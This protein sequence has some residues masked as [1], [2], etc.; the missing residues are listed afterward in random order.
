MAKW[1]ARSAAPIAA[2]VLSTT[3]SGCYFT[4]DWDEEVSGVPLAELD[5]SGDAP[6]TIRLRG[7]DKVVISEGDTLTITLDGNEDAGEA[8]RFDRDDNRLSIAR[9]KD[10]YDG[11]RTATVLISMPAPSNLEIAGSGNIEAATMASEAEI[12]IAIV[13]ASILPLPAISR[14][15]GA[16]IEISTVAVREPS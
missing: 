10:V 14:F 16:G 1:F 4:G 11:S 2:L 5:M 13:A 7:P 6:D 3:V 15:D 12:E 8:L 9:D